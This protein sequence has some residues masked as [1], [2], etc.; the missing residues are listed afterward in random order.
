MTDYVL[1]IILQSPLTSAGGEGRVG[2]VDQ[3]IVYDDLGLPILPGRRLKGLWREAYRDVADA[4]R[5]C[6]N[7]AIPVEDIF[8]KLGQSGDGEI[9]LHVANA[10]WEKALSLKPW[11]VYLQDPKNQKLYP[12]DVVRHFAS[13]RAQTAIDRWTGAADENT[14]RLTRTLQAGLVFYA[15]VR[16][17][18]P[19]DTVLTALALGAA[20]LRHM[21]SARTRG[22]G[23]VC[24]QLFDAD[25]KCNLTE[26]ALNHSQLPA[27]TVVSPA[28]LVKTPNK[29]IDKQEMDSDSE[30]SEAPSQNSTEDTYILRYRLT[31]NEPT[32]IPK[33][34]GDPNAVVTRQ[35]VPGS[36]VWGAA[37]WCYL[38]Q[39]QIKEIDDEFR[40]LFLGETLRF[41]TAYPEVYNPE[42]DNEPQRTIPIPHSI[43]KFKTSDVLVDLVG[44]PPESLDDEQTKRYNGRY[45]RISHINGQFLETQV[46]KTE[47]NYHHARARDRRKGRALGVEERD[48]GAFF[49]YEAI[50]ADQS[51]QGAVL[52][53]I[54][55]LN[56][57]QRWLKDDQLIRIGRSRSAQYGEA[58]FEWIDSDKGPQQLSGL[59]EWDGFLP[60]ETPVA[61]IDWPYDNFGED[62]DEFGE[63]WDEE[64]G[65]DN[66]EAFA[67]AELHEPNNADSEKSLVI[68]SLSPLLTVNNH[69]HPEAC[70]PEAE[71]MQSIRRHV[72]KAELT[73]CRSYT[74][75]EVVGGYYTH[76]RL[77][78]QQW[79]AIAAGSVFVFKPSQDLSEDCLLQLEH[80]GLGIRKGEGYGRIAVNRL[81]LTNPDEIELDNLKRQPPPEEP[82]INVHKLLHGVIL[83]RCLAEIRQLAITAA[84]KAENIPSNALLGRVR[85]FLQQDP[86]V[87]VESLEHLRDLSKKR[88][89]KC[90][91]DMSDRLSQLAKESVLTLYDLFHKAWT[92]PESFTENLIV[93]WANKLLSGQSYA[94]SRN[95]MIKE[96]TEKRSK[97]MCKVFLDQLLTALHRSSRT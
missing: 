28:E 93:E 47:Q 32:V 15:P 11:L 24:C 56:A 17:E 82:N 75:T 50:K 6:N 55:D 48:G 26:L 30:N 65:W 18:P 5:L 19:D 52:G 44:R 14:L 83:A 79:P 60:R 85:L 10:E 86:C 88:L 92:K 54:D 91:I 42:E 40:H 67:S 59:A 90:E 22:L 39:N 53:T 7:L 69:G 94:D 21:G 78:R 81:K 87:A 96:L 49:R 8:G 57:L 77:P 66:G 13:V 73:L 43:R 2:V 80:E 95:A 16:V 29:Q 46:V 58:K 31:L 34:D 27:I 20:A 84:Q 61:Q 76:L 35:D 23:R 63:D 72:S 68:T 37:A 71:L 9:F 1:Q 74:Q 89:K 64:E 25:I 38:H 3:D 12:E 97:E 45:G 4:L 70:F 62:W 41:L 36:N 51:F 33:A